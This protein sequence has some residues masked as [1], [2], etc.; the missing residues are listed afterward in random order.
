MKPL[1]LVIML[2]ISSPF[3]C[4]MLSIN[5][6]IG[7][8]GIVREDVTIRLDEAYDTIEYTSPYRPISVSYS[9]NYT[10]FERDGH[11]VLQFPYQK[12]LSFQAVYEGLVEGTGLKV[13][14]SGFTG[15]PVE[16]S[17]TLPPYHSLSEMRPSAVPKPQSITTDGQRIRLHWMLPEDSD[18]TVFYESR[19]ITSFL[20][21]FAGVSLFTIWL[22]FFIFYV[23]SQ[24]KIRELLS[25][26]EVRVL[27]MLSKEERQDRIAKTLEFSKSKMSK[28]IRKLEEKNLIKKE[29]YFKTNK[30]TKK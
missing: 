3:V 26:D 16:L 15:G 19:R 4:S 7:R 29:P 30:I 28:V 21:L 2:V 14:R 27:D 17:V 6:D 23:R 25:D 18:V 13:F 20:W 10:L 24:R 12:E 22:V 9:G 5:I 1:Y 11:Y 8:T